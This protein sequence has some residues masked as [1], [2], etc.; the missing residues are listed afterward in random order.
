MS[1]MKAA[2]ILIFCS[3]HPNKVDKNLTSLC[4]F[5]QISNLVISNLSNEKIH[6]FSK[7]WKQENDEENT[8]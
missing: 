2:R 5:D 3:I 7:M 8:K 1:V 4:Y 6:F